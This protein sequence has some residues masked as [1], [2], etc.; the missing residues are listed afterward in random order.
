MKTYRLSLTLLAVFVSLFLS[1]T[2]KSAGQQA[3]SAAPVPESLP[4]GMSITPTAA[5]GTVFQLLNPD[6][7]DRPEFTADHPIT[8]ALSPDGSTLLIL[9]SGFNRNV[10]HK[11]HAIL[12]ESGE[13]VFVYDVHQQPPV[14]LQV[15]NVPNTYV[16]M[17]WAPDGERFYVSGG[18]N[19]NV[20]VFERAGDHWTASGTIAL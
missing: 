4:T 10:D 14:K 3:T 2:P 16:G 15:L 7:H 20:H 1:I 8:T 12:A 11:G 19:D 13:Y 9:T 6:L 17:A 18:V 5:K